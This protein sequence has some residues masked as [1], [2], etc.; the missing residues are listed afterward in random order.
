M[1][2]GMIK[3]HLTSRLL[4]AA[5]RYPVLSLTGPR[6]SGKTTLARATFPKYDYVSLEA[7]DAREFALS[8]PRGFLDRFDH[9]VILDEAQRAPDLFSYIQGLVDERDRPGE[10]VV[11]GSQNFLL[12]DKVSQ[13]L[14][15][16]AAILHLLPFSH[17]ELTGRTPKPP[18]ALLKPVRSKA[19]DASLWSTLFTG[20]YPRIHDKDLPPQ[21]WLG[22]YVQTYVERDVRMLVNVVDLEVFGRFLR[23]CAG[24]NGQLLDYVSLGNDCGVSN[25][26]AKR[27][28]SVLEASFLVKIL[29]PHHANFNKRLTKSPKLY[30][31]DTGLLCYLLGIRSPEELEVH[32]MRGA[33]FE[34]FVV[35]ELTKQYMNAGETPPLH[36]WRD[37]KGNEVDV[38]VEQGTDLIPIEVKSGKTIASDALAGLNRW[39]SLAGDT[40]SGGILIHGGKDA[41]RRN[42]ITI[43]PWWAF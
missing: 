9:G 4:E 11:T 39:L 34:A 37:S 14:A 21:D 42:D 20:F 10:F 13:S 5:K 3:R 17:G 36:F 31:L 7:P 24:R 6:Q 25:V 8:D 18:R 38:I 41:Y 26:T 35:S 40:A 23:L 12:S 22:N 30:F 27:W 16:R 29:R 33:V 32:S 19:P 2:A 28:I 1:E 43:Q 15:G